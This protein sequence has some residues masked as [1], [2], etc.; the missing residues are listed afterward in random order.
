MTGNAPPYLPPGFAP[1]PHA[2]PRTRPPSPGLLCSFEESDAP[3]AS[4]PPYQIGRFWEGNA[5]AAE[6]G[7]ASSEELGWE[8]VAAAVRDAEAPRPATPYRNVVPAVPFARRECVDWRDMRAARLREDARAELLGPAE[9]I[10][11]PDA[12]EPTPPPPHVADPIQ[13]SREN[14]TGWFCAPRAPGER[15]LKRCAPRLLGN[16]PLDLLAAIGRRPFGEDLICHLCDHAPG[17]NYAAG[18]DCAAD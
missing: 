11:V 8:D 3:P 5:G 1:P 17:V 6:R 14:I 13:L 2:D 12:Q 16:I 4:A 9:I 7:Y 10:V 18:L 15:W